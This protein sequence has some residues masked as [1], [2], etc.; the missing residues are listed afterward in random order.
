MSVLAWGIFEDGQRA[1]DAVEQ[2]IEA[3]FPPDEIKVLLRD[4]RG[5]RD[6]P[7]ERKTAVPAG[8]AI[9]AT[10]GAAGVAGAVLLTGGG[11]LVAAGPVAALLQAAGLGGALGGV[12]GAMGGLSWW[13]DE[14]DVP[15]E[16][17]KKRDARVLVLIPVPEERS[18]EAQAALRRA[19]AERVG[20]LESDGAS[21][22]ARGESLAQGSEQQEGQQRE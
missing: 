16:A 13:K 20:E 7:I 12:A 2:L 10:L 5:F 3:S 21:D 15:E 1:R 22:V 14:P 8:A 11:A 17:D 18:Q 6:V 9:G 19:N 4:E